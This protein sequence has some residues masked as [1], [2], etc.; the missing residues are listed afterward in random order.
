MDK[1]YLVTYEVGDYWNIY[2]ICGTKE[3]AEDKRN[4]LIEGIENLKSDYFL[5]YGCSYIA[6]VRNINEIEAFEEKAYDEMVQRVYLFQ[7]KY[8]E[9]EYENIVVEEREVI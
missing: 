5:K 2:S 9:L 8:E 7:A 3:K 1:V 4:D 6:D